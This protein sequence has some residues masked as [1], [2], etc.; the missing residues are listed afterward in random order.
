MT[1]K[2]G[3]HGGGGNWA[4]SLWG[5]TAIFRVKSNDVNDLDRLYVCDA[6]NPTTW[7][8][9]DENAPLVENA[10]ALFA[11]LIALKAGDV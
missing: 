5:K 9:Y 7:E 3:G 11:G 2:S 1:Y 8:D 10:F 6:D 4:V